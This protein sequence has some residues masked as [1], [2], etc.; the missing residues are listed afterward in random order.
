M[1]LRAHEQADKAQ[2]DVKTPHVAASPP[3][4]AGRVDFGEPGRSPSLLGGS[5][6]T[7]R[8]EARLNVGGRSKEDVRYI[9]FVKA[10]KS[11]R[12]LRANEVGI[13][14][15]RPGGTRSRR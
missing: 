7:V 4:L 2:A 12:G 6:V 5:K 11:N 15:T 8:H 1:P 9:R 10:A 13:S 3:A 14:W